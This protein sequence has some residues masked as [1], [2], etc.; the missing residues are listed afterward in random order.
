MK[1]QVYRIDFPDGYFYYGST[2]R[3]LETRLAQHKKERLYYLKANLKAG[4]LPQTP[5]DIY[6]AANGWNNPIISTH[7]HCVFEHVREM[8]DIEYTV[9]AEH[10]NDPKCL[11]CRSPKNPRIPTETERLCW[12]EGQCNSK[13]E[14]WRVFWIHKVLENWFVIPFIYPFVKAMVEFDEFRKK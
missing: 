2:I 13:Q 5:F 11:N 10:I 9:I 1:G 6:L 7:V 4:R 8:H 12:L 3:S 14:S